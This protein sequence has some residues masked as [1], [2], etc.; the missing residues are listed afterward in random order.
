MDNGWFIAMLV[1]LAI[2]FFDTIFDPREANRVKA[3]SVYE[4]TLNDSCVLVEKR[5]YTNIIPTYEAW[6]CDGVLLAWG[7]K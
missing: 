1:I 3:Y 2:I 6:T 7:D 5:I 4:A